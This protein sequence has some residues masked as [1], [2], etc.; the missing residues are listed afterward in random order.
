V[1]AE[2]PDRLLRAGVVVFAVGVVFAVTTLV[3]LLVGTSPLPTGV[4]LLSALAP[5]GLAMVLYGL[6][7]KARQHG[8]A[9][10]AARGAPDR[11]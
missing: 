7:R 9:T 2:P 3:P 5:L 6:W 4:Y 1:T 11:G 8:R 10:R